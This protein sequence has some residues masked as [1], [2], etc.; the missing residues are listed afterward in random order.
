[1]CII[2][3]EDNAELQIQGV[4]NLVSLEARNANVEG[5]GIVSIRD[6]IKSALRMRPDR[7][8]IGEIRSAEAIDYL[9]AIN[10]GHDGSLC[11]GHANTSKD[12]LARLETMA[13]IG[14]GEFPVSAIRRQIASGIDIIVHLGRLRDKTRKV[15]EVSEV[16]GYWDDE[17][18]L[19]TL[20]QYEE[21]GENHGQIQGCWKKVHELTHTEKLLAAGCYEKGETY[22]LD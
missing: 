12:M 20:Y 6:L 4:E 9:Q 17:I 19:Q 11:S 5:T 10:T 22:I 2:S 13:I 16:L 21:I 1:M 3:I 8:I 18:V 14:M 15:L 7:I